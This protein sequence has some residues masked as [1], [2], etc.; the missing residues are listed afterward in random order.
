MYVVTS[1]HFIRGRPSFHYQYTLLGKWEH[2]IF[3][4]YN[5]YV[6]SFFESSYDVYYI[7]RALL[8]VIIAVL[9]GPI[10]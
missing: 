6:I 4:H 8:L 7:Q 9:Q 2:F 1:N 3:H 5:S 10:L